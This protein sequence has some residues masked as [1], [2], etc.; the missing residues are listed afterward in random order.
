MSFLRKIERKFGRYAIPNLTLY[1]IATYVAGFILDI[2]ERLY[3]LNILGFVDLNPYAILHGQVWRLVTWVLCPP[4]QISVFTIIMLFCYYQLGNLLERTWGTFLYNVYIFIGLFFTVIGAFIVMMIPMGR[5]LYM[6]ALQVGVPIY[7]TIYVS[8]S[9]FLGFAL[10]YPEQTMLLYFVIP[11]KIKYLA[12]VELAFLTYDV[13]RAFRGGLASGMITL[14]MI[15]SSLLGT[16]LYWLLT[17]KGR[18]NYSSTSRRQHHQ[19]QKQFAKAVGR[20][21]VTPDGKITRH[22]C[23]ICG[24]TELSNPDL[25]FRFCSRCNGNYE[26]CQNHLFTHEHRK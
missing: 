18:W 9:I 16:L 10:T 4:G 1:I 3:D 6:Y 5:T 25:E 12:V 21:Q 14:T 7:S 11:I 13:I 19:R 26:Y 23:A 22:K 2:M 8:L 17:R 24:Q 20:S 15:V